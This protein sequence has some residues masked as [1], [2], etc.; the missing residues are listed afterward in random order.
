VKYAS[1]RRSRRVLR[2]ITLTISAVTSDGR[3]VEG[4]AETLV[5]GKHGARI[6]TNV[7]LLV[8]ATVRITIP[9]TGRQ[10]DAMV[11]WAS[12]ES[13]YEFGLELLRTRDFWGKTS[14]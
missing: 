10:A 5:L 14:S 11:T 13:P 3:V 1:Q 7:P 6:H 4:P 12:P 2:T 8:G 9:A